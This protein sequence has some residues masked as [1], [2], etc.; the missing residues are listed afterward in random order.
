MSPVSVFV[1]CPARCM[2]ICICTC[3]CV[4]VSVCVSVSVSVSV[5]KFRDLESG[6]SK[7]KVLGLERW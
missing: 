4:C 2:C 3:I 6:S 5:C 1:C 7:T